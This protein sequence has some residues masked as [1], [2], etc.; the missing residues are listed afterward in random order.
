MRKIFEAKVRWV[1]ERFEGIL[2]VIEIHREAPTWEGRVASEVVIASLF[3]ER[4]N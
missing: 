3:Y 4:Y 2:D 1:T